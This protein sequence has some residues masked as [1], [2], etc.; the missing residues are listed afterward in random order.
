MAS[1]QLFPE[2]QDATSVGG[3]RTQA[4]YLPVGVEGTAANTGTATVA[5]PYEINRLSEAADLFGSTSTLYLLVK[6]FLDRGVA[7][8]Q[9]VASKKAG[10][11]VLAERQA[12]WANLESLRRVRIRL[13]DSVTQADLVALAASCDNANLMSN[14]QIAIMGMARATSKAS[15]LTAATAINS[16]RA[17]LVAPGVDKGT[18]QLSGLYAAAA[19]AAEVAKN[20]D[21]A[22][23]LDLAAVFGLTDVERDGVGMPV[24]RQKVASGLLTNDFED[25][26]QGGV[27]PLMISEA[28]DVL[29]THLT[30]TFVDADGTYDALMTRIISDQSFTLVRDEC[31]RFK[32]LRKAN[33]DTNRRLL[34]EKIDKKVL[35]GIS[36][37]LR[38]VEQPDGTLG[39]N[40]AVVSSDDERQM[41]ITYEGHIVRG[42]STILVSPTLTINV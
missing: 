9:A 4:I 40:V 10:G 21:P 18:A 35:F 19:V 29:I 3:I 14:K 41:I 33:N 26:L 11:V 27:S 34:A 15:L 28:G 31:E 17:V 42:A 13:T 30:T 39:Y 8:V 5:R 1:T 20:G 2:I 23:D 16:S 12:A 22:D 37:W 6:E 32:G 7:A 24:F 38:P 25:L 36:D